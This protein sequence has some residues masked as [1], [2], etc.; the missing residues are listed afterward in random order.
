MSQL[1]SLFSIRK[2]RIICTDQT[3]S[4]WNSDFILAELRVYK[5]D[6]LVAE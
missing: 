5:E 3:E 2:H 6:L 4:A 1:K